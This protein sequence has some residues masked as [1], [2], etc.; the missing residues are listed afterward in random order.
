[1]SLITVLG[2]ESSEHELNVS[3]SKLT[4]GNFRLSGCEAA[5]PPQ[6]WKG[7]RQQEALPGSTWSL[8]KLL[9]VNKADRISKGQNFCGQRDHN[10]HGFKVK[11]V[12]LKH[13]KAELLVLAGG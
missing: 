5:H 3:R 2:L 12:R 9:T 8:D 7:H 4:R 10:K 13:V 6:T 11:V 1:M